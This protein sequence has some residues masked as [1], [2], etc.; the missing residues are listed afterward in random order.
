MNGKEKQVECS[1]SGG[2]EGPPP[3]TIIFRTEVEVAEENRCLGTHHDQYYISQH[4]ESK[5][6]I[7]GARPE[8]HDYND[9]LTEK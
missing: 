3:P 8:G 9:R 7:H 4:H 2:E 6:V 5:H 1:G